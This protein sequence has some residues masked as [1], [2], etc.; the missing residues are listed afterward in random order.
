MKT[1]FAGIAGRLRVSALDESNLNP[2]D[3]L[4]RYEPPA[5]HLLVVDGLPVAAIQEA[6]SDGE[7]YLE[8]LGA[9]GDYLAEGVDPEAVRDYSLYKKVI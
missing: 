6:V 3:K 7:R 4:V 5:E 2:G 1:T 9:D 8:F